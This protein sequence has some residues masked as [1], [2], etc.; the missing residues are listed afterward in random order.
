[1]KFFCSKNIIKLNEDYFFEFSYEDL[2]NLFDQRPSRP[3][4]LEKIKVLKR[5]IELR[6]EEISKMNE[7]MKFFKLELINREM[8][9]NKIFNANPHVGVLN[10]LENK[11]CYL[12][13]KTIKQIII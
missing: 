2:K 9:Y 13:L 11:V 5:E 3:E 4:D 1:M 10:P 8:N 7:K 6:D 12:N